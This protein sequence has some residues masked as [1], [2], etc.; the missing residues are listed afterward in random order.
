MSKKKKGILIISILIV[1]LLAL[2]CSFIYTK[3]SSITFYAKVIE[4][5][6]NS[7]LVE[8]LKNEKIY[9][10]YPVIE[11]DIGGFSSGDLIKVIVDKTILETYPP[12]ARVKKYEVIINNSSS[13]T[14]LSKTTSNYIYDANEN[15][16]KT[17]KTVVSTDAFADLP[18]ND[19]LVLNKLRDKYNNLVSN[20]NNKSF[21]DKAKEYL[22]T[23]V[24][25][26]FYNKPIK[27]VFFKD[28]SNKAKLKAISLVLRIDNI[29][30]NYF[31]EY[32]ENLSNNYKNAKYKLIELYLDKTS[33]YCANNDEVCDEAKVDFNL[34]KSSTN[35][36]WD[37]LKMVG[38]KGITKLKE[39][40]EIY[41][42]KQSN[43]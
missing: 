22:I 1:F 41:S 27:N 9:S 10:D 14:V 31:P 42:G 37:V 43:N 18:K 17:T 36:T 3:T 2:V 29:L 35:I 4:S 6:L 21:G 33:E 23:G 11:I 19:I 5:N 25:F 13:T 28:L 12:I 34:L 8:P 32:K 30:D 15:T 38:N 26:V 40:Y 39:W 20:Q 7:A 24:D 16:I